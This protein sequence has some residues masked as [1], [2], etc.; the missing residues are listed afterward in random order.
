ME[1]ARWAFYPS[2]WLAGALTVIGSPAA[3]AADRYSTIG[4]DTAVDGLAPLK[5][6]GVGLVV[7][8]RGK[9]SDPPPNNYRDMILELMQKKGIVDAQ[10]ILASG[11][12]TIVL[13]R[14]FI[15]PGGRKGDPLDVEV[16]VPPG[17]G[18]TSLKGGRLLEAALFESVLA[19]DKFNLKGKE[20]VR[21]QGP[22]LV[23]ESPDQSDQAALR[24]GKILGGGRLLIERNFRLILSKDSR[25]GRIT[26]V[27]AQRI[28]QRF[29]HLNGGVQEGVAKAKDDKVIELSIARPYRYDVE[30]YLLVTRKIPRT[31]SD[32]LRNTLLRQLREDLLD[33]ATSIDAALRL[34]AI[35][36]VAIPTLKE[37]LANPS[38]SVRFAAAQALC[39]LHDGTGSTEMARLAEASPAYRAYALGA[40]VALD[41]PVSRLHL[42]TLLG[43][44]SAETRYGAFRSLWVF[45]NEDPQVRGEKLNDEFFLHVVPG[46]CEPMVHVSRNFRPELVL[47]NDAQRLRTPLSLRAGEFI[48]IHAAADAERAYLASFRPGPNGTVTKRAE[49]SLVLADIVR[50]LV[51][52][53]ASYSD[54]VDMLQRASAS[55]VLMGRLEVNALPQSPP[56][57]VLEA[58]SA[59]GDGE[60][61]RTRGPS[62]PSLFVVP[63]AAERRPLVA[64]EEPKPEPPASKPKR[65]MGLFRRLGN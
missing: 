15:P 44:A 29:F 65:G 12:T 20:V 62:M 40:L 32:S 60:V 47:F 14:A 28:N 2:V 59:K 45:D 30:R 42:S 7:G 52:L 9:G 25:S 21:A 34:E 27:L 11:D 31:S 13:L 10:K 5:V 64:A 58:M 36:P 1:R 22:V 38:E 55:G 16:W 6:E 24:K 35:G 48:L 37:G 33:P 4:D 26:K 19:K 54:I 63:G 3:H 41:Q 57:E 53:G 56:L 39:Y 49:S 23:L 43:A 50:E 51:R 46:R 8:L 61:A 17:D 18:T